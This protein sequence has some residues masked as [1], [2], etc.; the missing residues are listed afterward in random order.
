MVLERGRT[1]LR[2]ANDARYNRF[3]AGH[4]AGF[5]EAF[6][7]IYSDFYQ[8]LVSSDRG[9]HRVWNSIGIGGP[10]LTFILFMMQHLIPP[11]D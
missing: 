4:P 6:A 8:I 10:V 2:E 11:F 7:N 3:K 9:R 5:V 1:E